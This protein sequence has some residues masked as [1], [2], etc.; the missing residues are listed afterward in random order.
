MDRV[1]SSGAAGT[2]PT[3]PASPSTG[4][5][6]AGNPGTGTP[7]T[8]PGP[9]WFHMITEE[10]RAVIVAAGLTPAHTS[11]TQ[12]RDAISALI[13]A[14]ASVTP[15][16]TTSVKGKVQLAIASEVASGTDANKAITAAALAGAT[17]KQSSIG[18]GQTY[19]DVTA[20]RALSTTYTNSSARPLV[21]SVNC[22]MPSTAQLIATVNGV[23]VAWSNSQQSG[24]ETGLQFIVP[25]GGTYSIAPTAGSPAIVKWFE[26]K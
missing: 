15:D 7:P 19:T 5:A 10:L 18:Y 8:K 13:S 25:P 22:T 2:A 11:V 21:V 12:L 24:N 3:P 6:T 17:I 16:A 23:A 20:S 9:W 14:G 4:Y 1:Y 26:L